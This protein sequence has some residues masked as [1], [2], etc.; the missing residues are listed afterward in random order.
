MMA[1]SIVVMLLRL[2]AGKRLM[3]RVRVYK[4]VVMALIGIMSCV[5]LSFVS[6]SVRPRSTACSRTL[7]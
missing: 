1:V 4:V 2:S 3:L 6:V 5:R 7:L